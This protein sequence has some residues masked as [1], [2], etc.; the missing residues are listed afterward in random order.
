MSASAA[1]RRRSRA[2]VV[3][4]VLVGSLAL[5][6]GGGRAHADV[7][8]AAAVVGIS[9]TDTP[10]QIR[11]KA[12]TVTP[13]PRQLAWQRLELTAF[14]HFGINTFTGREHGT[15]TEDPNAFQPNEL[16][17]DQWAAALKNAGFKLV[18]LTVKH[19]DGF[20]LFPS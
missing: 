3:A 7:G 19:H 8:T 13:S 12:A 15:G 9:P 4:A 20:L 11:A 16:N 14:I 18:V 5:P 1:S 6:G 2:A 17:T 10:A